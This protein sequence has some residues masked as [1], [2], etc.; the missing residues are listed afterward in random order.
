MMK[1]EDVLEAISVLNGLG[2]LGAEESDFYYD[3]TNN[4]R[5]VRLRAGGMNFEG[6]GDFVLGGI[7]LNRGESLG[8]DGLKQEIRL[9]RTAH[10]MKFKHVASGNV[11]SVIGSKKLKTV[12]EFLNERDISIHL[13]RINVLY[14]SII[15]L[16]ESV[17]VEHH[18][19]W[20]VLN[21]LYIKDRLYLA[22]NGERETTLEVLN[23][24]AFPDVEGPRIA[25]F[26]S[27]LADL[28]KPTVG[29]SD[30]LGK[31][32]IQVLELGAGLEEAAFIQNDERGLLLGDF[33][34]FYRHRGL[35]FP[36]SMH[37]FDNEKEVEGRVRAT[38]NAYEDATLDNYSFVDSKE[39]P[40]IQLAD[41]T[42]G[43]FAR[44]MN[45]CKGRSPSQLQD[46]RRNLNKT[47]LDNLRLARE[48]IDRSDSRNRAY[49]HHVAPISDQGS[50]S[51][52]VY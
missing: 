47:Q 9:D 24:F 42:V 30:P 50:W 12:L 26:Y 49:F 31:L 23:E 35:M 5:K 15:D 51:E 46:V 13:Q 41:V 28:V 37:Y 29:T 11:I 2:D 34:H 17:M 7:V 14:W 10:E 38:P 25:E 48:L 40:E 39:K 45:F 19:E 18:D 21:H 1:A 22:L 27:R 44:L 32:L 16:I 33:S 4:Y 6:D 43:C 20:L 36:K 8:L 3:E 52:F